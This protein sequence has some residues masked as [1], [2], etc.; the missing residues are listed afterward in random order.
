MDAH[1]NPAG[2]KGPQ[3]WS[4]SNV[5]VS[6]DWE[7]RVGQARK[8]QC[9][10]VGIELEKDGRNLGR[11]GIQ[12]EK[13]KS[14]GKKEEGNAQRRERSPSP[15][16]LGHRGRGGNKSP[17]QACPSR[18]PFGFGGESV[19]CYRNLSR[20]TATHMCRKYTPRNTMVVKKGVEAARTL[21]CSTTDVRNIPEEP[22][23]FCQ[24]SPGQE[25]SCLQ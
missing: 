11:K 17:K 9:P 18:P 5:G 21:L 19:Q 22:V 2:V 3:A 23:T 12:A 25:E 8:A 14:T 20:S 4:W 7:K 1:P 16:F 10:R 13:Q 15:S 24:Y 6:L